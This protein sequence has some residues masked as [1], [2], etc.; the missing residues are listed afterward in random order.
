VGVCAIYKHFSGFEFS[1]LS[2]LVHARPHAGIPLAPLGDDAAN[3][4]VATG[5][6][7]ENKVK[8]TKLYIRALIF[9]SSC[10]PSLMAPLTPSTTTT[11][12][13][14][15]G[16][17]AT[18][19]PT[20]TQ[21][22]GGSGKL[23]FE[24]YMIAYEKAFFELKGQVN[25]FTSDLDGTDLVPIT[26]GL[27]GFNYID[28]IYSDGSQ[29]LVS[30]F[31]GSNPQNGDLYLISLDPG[32]SD[33]LKI[34]S[35]LSIAGSAKWIDKTRVVYIGKGKTGSGIYI[36]NIDDISNPKQ[37]SNSIPDR[38]LAVDSNRVYWSN[39]IDN[40]FKDSSGS[41]YSYGKFSALWWTNI[42]G[43]GEGKFES[44]GKQIITDKWFLS[45]AFSPNGNN[46]AWIPAEHEP[47]CIYYDALAPWIRDGV[48]T[49]YAG[50]SAPGV[51]DK[52]RSDFGKTIDMAY[53]KAEAHR[54]FIMYVAS[55]S[56]MDNPVKVELLPPDEFFN[57]EFTFGNTYDLIWYPDGSRLSLFYPGGV[58]DGPAYGNFRAY[59]VLFY[60]IP[61]DHNPELTPLYFFTN[62]GWSM[63]SFSPDSRQIIV[64]NKNQ[65]PYVNEIDVLNLETM[66]YVGEIG[67]NLTLDAKTQH[68]RNI[69]WLP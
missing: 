22:G 33:P 14:T 63:L 54:C 52:N 9:L 6:P 64:A 59:P 45:F 42:D 55:L 56:Q 62:T 1:L 8:P 57:F 24:Y 18:L 29:V 3:R 20:P 25:I 30:S 34:A 51:F 32:M 26:N 39:T 15:P 44:K 28:S 10:S 21:I 41:I 31:S 17:A 43:S 27:Q 37:I 38:I 50:Q 23:I 49:K 48:Y 7:Y 12:I 61:M 58:W 11:P 65:G 2:S 67:R 35:G 40:R 60:T 66:K 46:I 68:I 4:W 5:E 53:I 16:P 36:V 47:D 69:Y 19:T 13:Q